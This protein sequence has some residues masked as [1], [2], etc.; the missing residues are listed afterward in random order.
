MCIF[1][2]IQSK[3]L[4]SFTDANYYLSM[5]LES[6]YLPVLLTT[7]SGFHTSW[8]DCQWWSGWWVC[9]QGDGCSWWTRGS[10]ATETPG[11][12]SAPPPGCS[13]SIFRTPWTESKVKS[14]RFACLYTECRKLLEVLTHR[15]PILSPHFHTLQYFLFRMIDK[16]GRMS[17]LLLW[18][19][20]AR[21]VA[22][23]GTAW[24][25]G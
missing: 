3:G 17:F 18:S 9:G 2:F 23:N 7:G 20:N 19:H 1:V 13:P 22:H 24:A 5:F 15:W 16:R 25:S 11:N 14:K 12:L 21:S 6:V 4:A 8:W 10:G